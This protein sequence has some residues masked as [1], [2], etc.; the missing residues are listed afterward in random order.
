MSIGHEGPRVNG[1]GVAAI[2]GPVLVSKDPRG[3]AARRDTGGTEQGRF[4]KMERVLEK[5]FTHVCLALVMQWTRVSLGPLKT[6][7]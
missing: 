3:L 5:A 1:S 2:P 6:E 7:R 4:R